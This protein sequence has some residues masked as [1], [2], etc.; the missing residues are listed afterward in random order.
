[1][2]SKEPAAVLKEHNSLKFKSTFFTT[3]PKPIFVVIIT[4]DIALSDV[5]MEVRVL[6]A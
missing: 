3:Q 2:D 1:M 4:N 6:H 5:A